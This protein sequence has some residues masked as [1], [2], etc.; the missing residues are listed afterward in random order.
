M[1]FSCPFCGERFDDLEGLNR[2]LRR[3]HR[4]RVRLAKFEHPERVLSDGC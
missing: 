3:R 2:H 4:G 1:S